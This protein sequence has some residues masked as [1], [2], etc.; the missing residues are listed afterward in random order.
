MPNYG[1]H[2]YWDNRYN[3]AGPDGSFDWL[4]TL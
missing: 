4:E 3:K 1:D 2:S